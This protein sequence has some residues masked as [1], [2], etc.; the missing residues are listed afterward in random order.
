MAV[1]G[2]LSGLFLYRVRQI[3]KKFA[4]EVFAAKKLRGRFGQS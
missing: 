1:R 3:R 4:A 2:T